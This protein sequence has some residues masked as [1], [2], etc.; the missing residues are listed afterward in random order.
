MKRNVGT[1][2]KVLRIIVGIVI[3]AVGFYFKSWWG[4]I[5]IIPIATGLIGYCMLYTIFGIS[6][7]KL[8]Q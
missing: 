8:K 5:G 3:I 7:C 1:I 4:V 6:T 2:D